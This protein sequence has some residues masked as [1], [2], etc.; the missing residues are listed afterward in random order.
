MKLK[1]GNKLLKWVLLPALIIFL[2]IF[3]APLR[4]MVPP[5]RVD[6]TR[7]SVSGHLTI[8][9]ESNEGQPIQPNE[10]ILNN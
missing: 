6:G 2:W 8:S 1:L 3:P 4:H 9:D 10:F 7:I 5:F